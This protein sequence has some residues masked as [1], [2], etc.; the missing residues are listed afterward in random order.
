MMMPYTETEYMRGDRHVYRHVAGEHLL[1]ALHRD[2]DAPM[3]AFT[4]T[5]AVLWQ[6]L[7][8]WATAERLARGLT[9]RFEVDFGTAMEDVRDFLGQLD[10]L[11]ALRRREVTT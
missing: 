10:S 6:S 3:Y 9:E 7:G 11:G 8:D 1:I 2:S 5:A 4:P